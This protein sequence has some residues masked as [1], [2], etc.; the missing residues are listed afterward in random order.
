M[1]D[2]CG[3]IRVFLATIEILLIPCTKLS[4]KIRGTSIIAGNPNEVDLFMRFNTPPLV[5]VKEEYL[6]YDLMAVVGS[7][8]GTMGLFIGFSFAS[9]TGTLL[10]CFQTASSIKR[11]INTMKKCEHID[12]E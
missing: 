6:I 8:G 3:K 12:Q 7:I 5:S 2:V 10:N 4:Y 1:S 9:L 11:K